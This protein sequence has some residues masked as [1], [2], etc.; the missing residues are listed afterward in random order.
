MT[1]RER[2]FVAGIVAVASAALAL[3]GLPVT[4]YVGV[5]GW[6]LLALGGAGM[7]DAILIG[8]G[9]RTFGSRSNDQGRRGG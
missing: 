2:T 3:A 5:V 1:D 9:V 7:I 4:R 8:L 6:A